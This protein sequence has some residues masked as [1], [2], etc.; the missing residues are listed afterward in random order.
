MRDAPTKLISDYAQV[1]I[2]N[3]VHDILRYLFIEGWQSEPHH[4]YQSL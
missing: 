2:S 1:E 3:K 4:Q